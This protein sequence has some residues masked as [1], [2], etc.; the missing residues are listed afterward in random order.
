MP[1]ALILTNDWELF[2]DGSGDYF[3]VQHRPMLDMLDVANSFGVRLTIMAEVLQQ[4]YIQKFSDVIA[5]GSKISSAW[6]SLL[7]DAVKDGHDVQLHLHPQWI[8]A[9]YQNGKWLLDMSRC[10]IASLDSELISEL[11]SKSKCYLEGLLAEVKPD[12]K[13]IAFRAGGYMIEPSEKVIRALIENGIQCDSSVTKGYRSDVLYDFTDAHSNILPWFTSS[14][15]VKYI[16]KNSLDLL[17]MP[18]YSEI[19]VDYLAIKKLMPKFYYKIKYRITIPESQLLWIRKRET[20]KNSRYPKENRYY[21]SISKK[22]FRWFLNAIA[23]TNAVQLD[24]DYL[25]ATVFVKILNNIL[26]SQIVKDYEKC[27]IVLPVIASGHIK[28]IHNC[29]NIKYILDLINK[30]LSGRVYYWTL[31][32]GINYWLELAKGKINKL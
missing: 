15:S 9:V 32:A 2:G 16:G 7:K 23:T 31:T 30:Q 28:D 8:G 11:I 5:N 10:S 1:I 6:E 18:I 21:K 24:Y 29:D 4:F 14:T 17:E 27:D 13:C 22:N 3:D 20:I 19:G 26:S 25:P 12:Y